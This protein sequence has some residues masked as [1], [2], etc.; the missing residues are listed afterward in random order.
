MKVDFGARV[1]GNL[2]DSAFTVNLN[3]D[4]ALANIGIAPKEAVEETIKLIKPGVRTNELGKVIE[5]T[6]RKYGY[7]P[8]Q[9][10]TGHLLEEWTIHGNKS[11]PCVERPH[12]DEMLEDE[13]WAVEVFASTGEG[14]WS[15][16][17]VL[18]IF[19][20]SIFL[21]PRADSEQNRQTH[22]RD[23]HQKVQITPF[24]EAAGLPR[25]SRHT[26]LPCGSLERTGKIQKY[27]VLQ[28]KKGVFIGQY[29]ATVL[30][31]VDGCEILTA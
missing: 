5:Q 12:G 10:L 11:I 20:S 24:R 2:V 21:R 26:N 14:R 19:S 13:L 18:E 31:T 6:V 23:D 8:I 25:K 28:E 22:I 3:Q 7:K 4:E 1:E 29:E 27:G 30:I 16:L 9:N 17:R 15:L